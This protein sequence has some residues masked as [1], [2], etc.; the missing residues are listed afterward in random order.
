MP[1]FEFITWRYGKD[2]MT[3]GEIALMDN[4]KFILRIQDIRPFFS[5][6]YDIICHPQ[7]KK[8]SDCNS[9]N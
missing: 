2:L 4:S 5:N 3:P 8:L 9:K 1:V 6:K 7:Y